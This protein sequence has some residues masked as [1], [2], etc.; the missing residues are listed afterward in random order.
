MA[1]NLVLGL[2]MVHLAEIQAAIFFNF[3]FFEKSGSVS[4]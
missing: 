2:T 4:H 1:K 3:F